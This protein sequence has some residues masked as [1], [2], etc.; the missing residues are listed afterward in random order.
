MP[1]LTPVVSLEGT[2]YQGPGDWGYTFALPPRFQAAALVPLSPLY[3]NDVES[4]RVLRWSNMGPSSSQ[5]EFLICH[6][7]LH[8]S[9]TSFKSAWGK[10]WAIPSDFQ[11]LRS[12]IRHS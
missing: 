6:F 2:T 7:N 8:G 3:N 4:G 10:L 11:G 5:C 9:E 12:L 1:Y